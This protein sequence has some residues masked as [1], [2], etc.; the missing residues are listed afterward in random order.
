M[1]LANSSVIPSP[2]QTNLW[3]L[4]RILLHQITLRCLTT[5]YNAPNED[6]QICEAALVLR[7]VYYASLLAGQMDSPELLAQEELENR[8]FESQL[9]TIRSNVSLATLEDSFGFHMGI[10][11]A[12]RL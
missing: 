7:M 4:Q 9:Q 1:P 3:S 6:K 2:E 10:I 8:E 5:D 12:D 11:S